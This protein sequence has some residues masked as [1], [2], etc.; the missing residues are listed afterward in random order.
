MLR[1][2]SITNFQA[3]LGFGPQRAYRYYI[4]MQIPPKLGGPGTEYLWLPCLAERVGMPSRQIETTQ[5]RHNGQTRNMP[6]Y[7]SYPP[8]QMT[9]ICDEGMKVKKLVD[10]WQSLICEPGYNY[11]SYYRD[12]ASGSCR[13]MSLDGAGLP[14]YAVQLNEFFPSR[15]DEVRFESKGNAY[16]TVEVE[17][18]Y[19]DWWNFNT[20]QAMSRSPLDI[21]AGLG[22]DPTA[23][24][25]SLGLPSEVSNVLTNTASSLLRNMTTGY[26]HLNTN[27]ITELF[28]GTISTLLDNTVSQ[29]LFTDR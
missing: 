3:A 12:Y 26:T 4:M 19:R 24:I 16:A 21:F 2:S 20:I 22:I 15:V 14:T 29:Q 1:P 9:F 28:A 8:V 10:A 6:I 13:V 11:M 27:L 7:T 25:S 18:T 23:Y 5:W 17:F